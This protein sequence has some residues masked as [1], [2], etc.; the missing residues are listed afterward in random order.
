MKKYDIAAYVWPSYTG[1]EPRTRIFWDEGIGEWQTV[2]KAAEDDPSRALP[3]WGFEDEADPK[4]MEKQID[5]AAYHGVNVF[6]YDWYWYDHRPFLEQC[7]DNGFLKGK[8]RSRMKF[9]I[10]WA[11]HDVGMVW[12]RRNA[13]YD[14]ALIYQ[15]AVDRK[16]F[17]TVVRRIIDNY[18]SQPEYYKIDGKP[19]FMIYDVMNL[20]KGLGGVDNAKEALDYFR[21][22]TVK[23]GFPG[24]ELQMTYWNEYAVNLSGVDSEKSGSASDAVRLLGFDSISHYQFIH[25]T[26]LPTDRP[27]KECVDNLENEWARI[28]DSCAAVYYPHVSA[29][30]DNNPRYKNRGRTIMT[31]ATPELFEEALRKAKAY[32]D[33]REGMT[34]LITVNSWN[35]WTETSYL[36]PDT[37]YGYAYLEAIKRVFVDG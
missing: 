11:N 35:E 22:E 10:M 7:L 3:L 27:Y 12:D 8:N 24:L 23:A 32:V 21:N 18:F 34:P 29:G 6:I 5:A 2:R 31:G 30:W 26:Y 13:D 36:E 25:F 15:G 14:E 4:V 16:D 9:Y 37:K 1:T 20:L 19:V 33:A 17:E 28:N